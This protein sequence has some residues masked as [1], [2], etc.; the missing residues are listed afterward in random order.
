MRYRRLGR[1][2]FEVS[3]VG[4]GAWGIGGGWGPKRDDEARAA[5]ERALEVGVNLVDTALAY[6]EGHSERLVGEVVRASGRRVFVATKVPPMDRVW[7][8]H[9]GKPLRAVFPRQHVLDSTERSLEHLGLDAI[10]LQQ[11]HVWNDEWADQDEWQ[12]TARELKESGRVR[13]F[14]ISIND[15]EPDN[16]LRALETGLI[17]SVQVIY[18]IFDQR[19]Q[20]RLFPACQR[21]DVG[22][23]ARVPLDEGGLTGS[24]R[25]DTTFEP[26][27]WREEYFKGERKREVFERAERLRFLLHDGVET[28]AEAALRFTLSN[29]AVTTVIPGMRS[30]ARVDA[31]ARAS[32]GRPLPQDDLERLKEHAWP[33]NFYR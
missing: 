16:A 26:G 9:A 5:L 8:A 24:V 15:H 4:F 10:D 13:A 3:E 33:R 22:V 27:D 23:L 30:P 29:P 7:P 1:T 6:G 18:N 11:L 14:G 25:P 20:E 19:P 31:N 12:L 28:L 32:D 21:L 2:G 17:D